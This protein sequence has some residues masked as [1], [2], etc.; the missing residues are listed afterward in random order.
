MSECVLLNIIF[1]ITIC[2]DLR[3]FS[4]YIPCP[5]EAIY[6]YPI[7]IIILKPI[8][9]ILLPKGSAFPV[10]GRHTHLHLLSVDA[11]HVVMMR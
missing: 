5:C 11:R 8:I 6:Y 7:S 3:G 1:Y 10:G 9:I 2:G 4:A